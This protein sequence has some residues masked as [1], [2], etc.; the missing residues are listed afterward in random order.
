MCDHADT[1][2]NWYYILNMSEQPGLPSIRQSK[3]V[4]WRNGTWRS[5]SEGR[6]KGSDRGV[7]S[8][9]VALGDELIPESSPS[10]TMTLLLSDPVNYLKLRPGGFYIGPTWGFSTHLLFLEQSSEFFRSWVENW[11]KNTP[12][13]GHGNY[14]STKSHILPQM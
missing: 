10:C 12:C 6:L 2:W 11:I 7:F 8:I 1:L 13:I 9:Q 4:M 14:K 3:C 5:A